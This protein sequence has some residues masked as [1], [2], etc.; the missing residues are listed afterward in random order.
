[1]APSAY[2]FESNSPRNGRQFSLNCGT[3]TTEVER[4]GFGQLQNLQSLDLICGYLLQE[5]KRQ[6]SDKAEN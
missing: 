3:G 6:L 2:S 4:V 1:M 5:S